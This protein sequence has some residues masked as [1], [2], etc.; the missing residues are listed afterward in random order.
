[1]FYVFINLNSRIKWKS[2]ITNHSKTILSILYKGPGISLT[3]SLS[4]LSF[5]SLSVSSSTKSTILKIALQVSLPR[6]S[7]NSE[8]RLCSTLKPRFT[9]VVIVSLNLL[10]KQKQFKVKGI[11][12]C[13]PPGRLLKAPLL[14][15]SKFYLTRACGHVDLTSPVQINSTWL[16]ILYAQINNT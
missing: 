13:C 12:F 3:L 6:D 14:A 4:V 7:G 10:F 11:F 9:V 15:L 1:M 5:P 8:R 16:P 2:T